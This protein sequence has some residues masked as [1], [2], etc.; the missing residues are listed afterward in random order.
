LSYSSPG[1]KENKGCP[2]PD[3]DGDGFLDKDDACPKVAGVKEEKGCPAKPKEVITQEAKA[4]LDS[5]AKAIYFNS[6]KD[7]FMGGVTEKLDLIA[8]IMKQYPDANF[9]IEGHTDSDGS[10][11]SN[12]TLSNKRA[13]AVMKYLVG[14]GIPDTR[15]SAQGF[16][17]ANPIADNKTKEGKGLNRRVQIN[18]KK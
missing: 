10:D 18:L 15:L 12:L 9:A 3:T 8:D 5:F 4:Q 7:T 13:S 17:E 11:A 16:G 14:K 6:A 2:W 1:P